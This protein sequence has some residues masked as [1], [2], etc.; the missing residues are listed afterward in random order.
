MYYFIALLIIFESRNAMLVA[1]FTRVVIEDCH[2]YCCNQLKLSLF[3]NNAF[4]KLQGKNGFNAVLP[5]KT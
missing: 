2:I 4:T 3:Y 5:F 1:V